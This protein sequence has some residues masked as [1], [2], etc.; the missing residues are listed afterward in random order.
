MTLGLGVLL[1]TIVVG[2][3]LLYRWTRDRWNWRTAIK[4]LSLGA[5]GLLLIACGLFA[6]DKFQDR[7][8]VQAKYHDI[9]LGMTK[10]EVNYIK[11]SPTDVLVPVAS[12]DWIEVCVFQPIVDAVSA[13]S[14][15]AFQRNVDAISG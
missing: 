13:G 4:R 3:L 1:S 14:W 15:T 10:E 11:G 9:E 2:L 12:K 7:P 6:Y 8:V 5:L